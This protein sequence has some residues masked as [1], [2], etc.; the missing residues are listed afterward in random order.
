[1]SESIFDGLL[2]SEKGI[3][4]IVGAMLM[5]G[6]F[7]LMLTLIQVREVPEWNKAVEMEHNAVIYEDFLEMKTHIED[8]PVV[9]LPRSGIIHMG[10]H[11]PDR[12][13]LLNPADTSGTIN[14]KN[15]TWIR[16]DYTPFNSTPTSLN[17]SSASITYNPNYNFFINA[18]LLV[19]EH[20][21]VIKDINNYLYTDT[22]QAIFGTDILNILTLDFAE[23]SES[24]SGVKVLN[25][26]PESVDSTANNTNVSV[27]FYTNYPE[28]WDVLL[29]YH[30]FIPQYSGNNVI[31]IEYSG[32]IT[33]NAYRINGS[34]L[35][36]VGVTR[37]PT[38]IPSP[39]ATPTP[40]PTPSP[41]PTPTPTPSPTPTATPTP[42]P[43]PPSHN[44]TYVTSNIATNGTITN[45]VNMKSNATGAYANLEEDVNTV[46]GT[47]YWWGFNTTSESWTPTWAGSGGTVT[48]S[49]A[50]V[51]DG[52]PA[53]GIYSR[54]NTNS[55]YR[56]R[57]S[58]WTSPGFTWNGGIPSSASLDFDWRVRTYTIASPG[59]YYVNLVKPDASIVQIYP[60]TSFSSTSGWTTKSSSLT[61]GDF[62]QPGNYQIQLV[63]VLNTGYGGS[64]TVEVRWD[65]PNI[66]LDTTTYNLDI[67]TN[68]TSVPVDT[69]YYLEIKY[70]HDANETGYDV[71]VYDGTSWNLKGSL[72]STTW[73]LAN[74][75]L[76][77]SEVIN[78]NV[79]VRYIDQTPSGTNQGNLYIDY[80]RIHGVTI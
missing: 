77:S 69:N 58:T 42:T 54:I 72:A 14:M 46:S 9:R 27:T 1:M 78:G 6:V 18:P 32:N 47:I 57:T 76:S 13:I 17:I 48:T 3:S 71:F 73:S 43:T 60:T 34:L 61:P 21:L 55:N 33:I 38:P 20:G 22:D 67:D 53:G 62:S 23:I 64:K 12:P 50:W 79:N 30:N 68:T 44:Y 24:S 59:S 39:T 28:L 36:G 29:R 65:N 63:A 49:S 66:M 51:N 52:N 2:K 26:I 75:T 74:F 7:V 70:S 15:D 5:L 37:T 40:T 31:T 41:T 25:F 16:V 4:E 11:Y 8:I 35:S 80:Q 56:Q 10:V 19:Y 45:F